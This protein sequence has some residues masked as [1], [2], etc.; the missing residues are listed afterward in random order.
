YEVLDQEGRRLEQGI[1]VHHSE[2]IEDKEDLPQ[3][4][5]LCWWA[6][7]RGRLQN[8]EA[9]RMIKSFRHSKPLSD[10]L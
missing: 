3:P 1:H 10:D 6:R 5:E 9:Y 4:G 7:Q 8:S 2:A